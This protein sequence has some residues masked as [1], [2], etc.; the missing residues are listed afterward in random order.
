[1]QATPGS[2]AAAQLCEQ[3]FDFI[4]PEDSGQ[5]RTNRAGGRRGQLCNNS[6]PT[7]SLTLLMPPT[8]QG[9]TTAAHPTFLAYLPQTT[10]K[11][12]FL[13]LEDEDNN[14]VYHTTF[15]SPEAAGIVNFSIPETAPVLEIDKYYK[16]SLAMICGEILDPNDLVIEGWIKRI[17]PD[18]FTELPPS[19]ETPL[20][21]GAWYARNGVWFDAVQMLADLRIAEPNNLDAIAAWKEL[22]QSVG[23]DTMGTLPLLDPVD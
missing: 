5:P 17:A 23:L 9:N 16:V 22:L 11:Q 19:Q 18:M 1:M 3:S 10:A 8:N 20:E 4:P 2:I 14:Y 15:E 7:P 12:V 21:L 6:M 13:S